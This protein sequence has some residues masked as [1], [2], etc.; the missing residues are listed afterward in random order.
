MSTHT[1][2]KVFI[3]FDYDEDKSLKDLFIGQSRNPICPF[4]VIDNSLQEAAPEKE[5]EKKAETKM[6][7]ADIV[8][9]LLGAKTHRAPGVLKEIRL[10]RQLKKRS[11]S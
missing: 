9:V 2:K 7:R 3:S 5:W 6:S 10:A 11:S 1:K 4:E 8:I